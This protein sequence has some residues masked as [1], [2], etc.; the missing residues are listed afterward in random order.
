MH[1][2]LRI[3]KFLGARSHQS[4]LLLNSSFS[5]LWYYSDQWIKAIEGNRAKVKD[6]GDSSQEKETAASPMRAGTGELSRWKS[7]KTERGLASEE[8]V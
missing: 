6:V 7:Q 5:L 8:E 4:L 1:R 2:M 3:G